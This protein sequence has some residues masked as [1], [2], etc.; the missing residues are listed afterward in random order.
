MAEDAHQRLHRLL[1]R[2]LGAVVGKTGRGSWTTT[3]S[4]P[5]EIRLHTDASVDLVRI[6]AGMVVDVKPSKALLRQLNAL[7]TERALTR[8]IIV[9]GKVLVVAEMPVASLRKGDLEELMSRVFCCARLDAPLLALHGGRSVT[10]LPPGLAPDVDR[11][12][13]CWE[14]VLRASGTATERELAVWLDQQVGGDFWIDQDD[15]SLVVVMDGQGI[16]TEYPFCLGDLLET[17]QDVVD[18]SYED[19]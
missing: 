11:V 10:D 5:H 15:E 19:A 7:D 8:R 17:A 6:S 13:T 3:S 2:D 1:K 14:D 12:L 9:D 16:G 18:E 4:L